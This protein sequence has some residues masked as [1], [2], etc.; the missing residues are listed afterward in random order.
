MGMNYFD[1]E[2][3]RIVIYTNLRDEAFKRFA[4]ATDEIERHLYMVEYR[5]FEDLVR[6]IDDERAAS[7]R[8]SLAR[9]FE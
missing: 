9:G 4:E 8:E 3:L 2:T 1:D 6:L 5:R 7:I